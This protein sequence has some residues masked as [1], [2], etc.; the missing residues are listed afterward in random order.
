MSKAQLVL[1]LFGI[2]RKARS[3]GKQRAGK[4]RLFEPRGCKLHAENNV[5]V[6][7]RRPPK[8]E[9]HEEDAEYAACRISL[10]QRCAMPLYTGDITVACITAR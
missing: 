2:S 10:V 1:R 3:E 8:R 4:G 9:F 6:E 5:G 7:G